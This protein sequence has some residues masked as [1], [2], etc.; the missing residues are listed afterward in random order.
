MYTGQSI[1][2][3]EDHRLLT[4]QSSYEDDIVRPGMPSPP[5]DDR[6]GV[7]DHGT[8]CGCYAEGHV[9]GLAEGYAQRRNDPL[10]DLAGIRRVLDRGDD[11]NDRRE[12]D[13]R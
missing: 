4:G 10:G 1:K 5:S 3:F 7:C 12:G 11:G 9:V 2:R 13:L 8:P 6:Q